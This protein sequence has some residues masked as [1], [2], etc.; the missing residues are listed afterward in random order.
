[1][2]GPDCTACEGSG[3]AECRTNS[4]ECDIDWTGAAWRCIARHDCGRC[5]GTGVEPRGDDE[6]D[7]DADAEEDVVDDDGGDPRDAGADRAAD[8]YVGWTPHDE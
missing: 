6:D 8:R 3:E 1:M 4:E 7:D 5:G 2:T